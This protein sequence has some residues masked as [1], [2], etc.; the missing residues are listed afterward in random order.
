M[1][2]KSHFAL[3]YALNFLDN[4]IRL[5][6]STFRCDSSIQKVLLLAEFRVN[7]C[8]G[9]GAEFHFKIRVR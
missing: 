4:R 3:R 1:L 6:Y 7:E 2:R 5:I 8:T 9:Q